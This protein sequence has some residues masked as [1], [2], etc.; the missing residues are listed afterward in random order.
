[1]HSILFLLPV[2]GGSGGAHSV[3]QEAAAMR[4]MGL[5]ARIATNAANADRL[6]HGYRD[7]PAI[8]GEIHAYDGT[9]ELAALIVRLAPEMVVATTNQSV[10]A[11]HAALGQADLS[12]VRTA[13][14]I[15][16]YEPL[17]Y[18][19]DSGEW[20]MARSSYGL[21]PGAVHFAKTRWL[22]QVVADNH[23]VAV[24]RVEPSIDHR[25]YRPALDRLLDSRRVPR[26]AAMVRPATPRRAPQRTMRIL[27]ALAERHGERVA[28]VSFGCPPGE[29]LDLGLEAPGVR[30]L[31]VLPREAVGDLFRDTDLFLDLSDYQA[32]G[33]SA[34][35]AMSCGT[36]VV[37]PAHG[38]ADAFAEDGRN[39]F[40]VDTRSDTAILAAVDSFLAMAPAER[41]A[42]ALACV[43][44]GYRFTPERA[45]LSEIAALFG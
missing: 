40:V 42:M 26:I 31:G 14:Y 23:Q 22:Q 41:R 5:D 33:R 45:A 38:G 6:R 13:Y 27:Q 2:S 44:T 35:E 24:K 4:A 15:Q 25:V 28:C 11:L 18:D 32:F 17:F 29:L 16:D 39:A 21:I 10:H 7:L 37:V 3:M 9:A 19:V 20:A 34:V 8:A 1:M 12:A 30:H 43:E 36:A